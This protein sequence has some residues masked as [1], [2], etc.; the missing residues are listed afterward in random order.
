MQF[1]GGGGGIPIRAP[2]TG[3]IVDVRVSPGAYVQEGQL[4]FHIAD[5]RAMW[6]ELRVPESEATRASAPSGAT[7][8][9][10]G[11]DQSFEV[12]TG[13][14]ARLIGAGAL[15]DSTT[16]TVP[17]LFEIATPHPGLKIGMAVKARVFV[18]QTQPGLAVPANAVVDESGVAVVFVQTGGESFQRRPVRTGARDGDWIQI[19]DGL[20]PGQRVVTRGAYLVK[21]AATKTGG[22]GHG[23]AH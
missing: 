12:V 14:N 6:L 22:I 20:E 10:E 11:I 7:F 5:A 18:G 13:K 1:G 16:R 19:L 9:V 23:H 17:V 4:L 8:Q 2:T 21:L 3:A 15:V